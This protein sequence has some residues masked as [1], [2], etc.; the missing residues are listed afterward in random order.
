MLRL[1]NAGAVATAVASAAL[2]R[3]R[4]P[5]G[6]SSLP[7]VCV[8]MQAASV[9]LPVTQ[10]TASPSALVPL[11]QLRIPTSGPRATPLSYG[12]TPTLPFLRGARLFRPSSLSRHVMQYRWIRVKGQEKGHRQHDGSAEDT[13]NK[14]EES[15]STTD[16]DGDQQRGSSAAGNKSGRKG[17]TKKKSFIDHIRGL[18]D[19]YANFPHIYNSVNAI[20]FVIFTAFCL[21]STG[22][23]TEER[24]WL[25]KWSVDNNIHPWTWLLHSFLTNNF[26]AMT[27]SMM[28]LHT[29]CHHLLPTLGSRGLMMYC[30]ST[31]VISGAIMFLG[32]HLY[33]DS[34]A[35]P[36]KQFGPWD[37]VAGLFVMEYLYYG[38]TPMTILNSFSG[39]IKYA[40]WVGEI[41]ILYFDW[42]P[43]LVG[44]LVGLALCKG[45][46]RFKAAKPATKAA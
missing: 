40:C 3:A 4:R 18:R 27:F 6:A 23:N 33:Y 17:H 22:S 37:V 31:A 43:T 44:T 8:A 15:R 38:L 25:E 45:V 12:A 41:C 24:W 32:N 14:G 16:E 7:C 26:L 36:E 1:R 35:S 20:N 30:G 46:P 29:M 10:L 21:C 34:T 42:Q 5:S 19:D 2:P 13:G 28:L 9:G 11:C 39:W